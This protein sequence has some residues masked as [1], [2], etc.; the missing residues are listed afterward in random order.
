MNKWRTV[1]YTDEGCCLYECLACKKRWEARTAPGWYDEYVETPALV[2]GGHSI[3]HVGTG[4]VTH[5]A[6]RAEPLYV[7]CWSYCPYCG[8]EWEGP[9]RCDVD[10]ERMLGERRL[11]IEK[12]MWDSRRP[13]KRPDKWIIEVR[14]IWGKDVLE[15]QYYTSWPVGS[16]LKEVLEDARNSTRES[17]QLQD[18]KQEY[19]IRYERES[20]H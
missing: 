8:T 19:R 1:W 3:T 7:K 17:Y 10:N 13:Y 14:T 16:N 15:W 20:D 6:K 9:I 4:K 18:Y 5:Y 2:E 12:A 11:R